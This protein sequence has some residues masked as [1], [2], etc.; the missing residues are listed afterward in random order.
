MTIIFCANSPEAEISPCPGR[1]VSIRSCSVDG[2]GGGG[3]PIKRRR[4]SS[5]AEPAESS[6]SHGSSAAFH[7]A[8]GPRAQGAVS[9]LVHKIQMHRLLYFLPKHLA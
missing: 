8:G 3:G 6:G 9:T 7:G 2:G 4:V 5:G 1:D